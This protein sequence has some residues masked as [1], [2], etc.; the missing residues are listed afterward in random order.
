MKMEIACLLSLVV[1][2]TFT[3]PMRASGEEMKAIQLMKAQ[4]N[5]GKPLMQVLKERKTSR[6]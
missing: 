1:V 2:F 4:T 6:E 5:I 3:I